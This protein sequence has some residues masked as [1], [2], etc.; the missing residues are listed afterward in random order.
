[1]NIDLENLE[2]LTVIL[3]DL[4]ESLRQRVFNIDF[5]GDEFEQYHERIRR[6]NTAL[7]WTLNHF[8]YY[9]LYRE[10]NPEI[11]LVEINNT[12]RQMNLPAATENDTI[13]SIIDPGDP[14]DQA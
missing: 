9:E 4:G 11:M 3:E 10:S 8:D 6:M 1:M 2:M 14:N 7:K 5:A 12:L 13:E